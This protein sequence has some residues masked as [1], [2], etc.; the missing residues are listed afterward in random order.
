LW[1]P[2]GMHKYTVWA[3]CTVFLMLRTCGIYS[4]QCALKK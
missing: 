3:E 1:E 2:Y 4:Y